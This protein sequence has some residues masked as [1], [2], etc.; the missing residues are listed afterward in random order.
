MYYFNTNLYLIFSTASWT[1]ELSE[2]HL[3]FQGY[4]AAHK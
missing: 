2:I 3:T 4:V 1:G